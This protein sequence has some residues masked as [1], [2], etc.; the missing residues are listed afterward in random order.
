MSFLALYFILKTDV[1]NCVLDYGAILLKSPI[2]KR[3]Q[4]LERL[5]RESAMHIEVV[6]VEIVL[7]HML[8]VQLRI[9]E[10]FQCL[11]VRLVL[12]VGAACLMLEP[13]CLVVV[14]AHVITTVL[15]KDVHDASTFLNIASFKCVHG[16][17][18]IDC[19]ICFVKIASFLV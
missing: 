1:A 19:S 8:S 9:F 15:H 11:S 2:S 4:V 10:L 6:V 5:E 3:A 13:H 7:C 17:D 16:T 18:S 14:N 12:I